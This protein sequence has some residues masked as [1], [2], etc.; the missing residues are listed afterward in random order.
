MFG[1]HYANPRLPL[2]IRAVLYAVDHDGHDLARAELHD[3]IDP[4]RTTRVSE[5]C[6][7]VRQAVKAGLL[8]QGS[9]TARL[10]LAARSEQHERQAG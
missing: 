5:V 7:A 3:A 6:R 9:S 1:D 4:Q 8:E 2:W 10:T